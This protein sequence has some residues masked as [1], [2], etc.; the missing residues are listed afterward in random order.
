M[1]AITAATLQSI[2]NGVSLAYNTQLFA[3]PSIYKKFCYDATSTGD[4]EFYPRMDMLFGLREWI[5][6]RVVRGV[7]EATFQISNRTFEETIGIKREN[8]EDDKYGILAPVA[9]ELGNAAGRFPDLLIAQLM[10]S[11]TTT[12]TFDNQNFFDVAHPNYTASGAPTTVPNYAAGASPGWYLLDNSRSIK[13]F[14][15]QTRRPFSLTTRF[16][17]TDPTV[18]DQNEFRWGTDGRC[19]AGFGL[20]Y[21]A[22]YS[23]QPLTPANIVAARTQMLTLRRPDGSPMGIGSNVLLVVP[24]TIFPTAV[25]IQ[26][27]EFDPTATGNTLVPNIARGLFT[28]LENVWLN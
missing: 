21:L 13:S 15:F 18:F 23:T 26:N 25:Q 16:S 5:G 1:A 19:N 3:A 10:K 8:I 27:N 12:R 20:W 9:S 17:A 24:S 7:S 11:G 4:A 2:T 28:T 22:Y 14:I 6:E